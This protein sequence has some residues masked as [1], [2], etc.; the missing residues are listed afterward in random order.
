MKSPWPTK[1]LGEICNF[2]FGFSFRADDFNDKGLGMPVIRTGDLNNLR[3]TEKFY[4]GPYKDEYLVESGDI[5]IGLSGTIISGIWQGPRALLNQRVVKLTNFRN[6][7]KK[8]IGYI[9]PLP[10]KKLSEEL[11]KS[12]VKNVL[13]NHLANLEIPLPPLP[14]QQKIVKI[15]DTIQSA[16][17]IQEKIIEKTKELKKSLMAE[18]FKYGGPSFRK[19]RKLKKTE[20]LNQSELGTGQVGEIPEDWE[21]VRLGKY[22]KEIIRGVNFKVSELVENHTETIPILRATNMGENDL[23]LSNLIYV[24]SYKVSQKQIIRKNDIILV[25]SSGSKNLVGRSVFIR[26]EP[27]SNL[28]IGAFLYILRVEEIYLSPFYLYLYVSS[29]KFE[30]YLSSLVGGTNINNLQKFHIENFKVPLPPLLEQQEIAEILRTID[31]KIEIEKKKKELYEE[32]FKTMLNK[33][34]SQEIDIG[35]IEI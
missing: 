29:G 31:Q 8:F 17:E 35:K 23:I 30:R 26:N 10:L 7:E 1:K 19:G 2:I 3:K 6:V 32:L 34:M 22:I 15:L 18:L 13:K 33:I 24:P 14:I 11:T 4:I 25:A 16:V 27:L 9:L 28:A 12:A 20:T 5:L 21:V